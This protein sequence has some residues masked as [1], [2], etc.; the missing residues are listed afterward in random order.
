MASKGPEGTTRMPARAGAASVRSIATAVPP[1]VIEQSKVRDLFAAQPGLTPL[2][3][4]LIGSVFD[5]SAIERRHTVLTELGGVP[6][7]EPEPVFC[8][9]ASGRILSP[10]TG[11]RNA[12]YVREVPPLILRAAESAIDEAPGLDRSDITHVI[13]VSC[14]GLRA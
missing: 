3:K 11:V 8:D 14:T 4:R 6:G 1:I 5:A 13:T 10:S 12:V 2:A 7:P 9:P